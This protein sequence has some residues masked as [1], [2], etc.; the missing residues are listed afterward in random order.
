MTNDL[1]KEIEPL[2]AQLD[3]ADDWATGVFLLLE[4]VLP[5]LLRGHP[6]IAKIQKLLQYSTERYEELQSHPERAEDDETS[7]HYEASKTMYRQ[8]ILLGVW[9]GIDPG[10]A[11]REIFEPYIGRSPR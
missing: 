9:P 5:I 7:G 10:E 3:A 2:R 6:E 4:Q 11:A 8:M 1:Q